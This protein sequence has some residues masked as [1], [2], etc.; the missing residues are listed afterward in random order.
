M[1][2]FGKYYLNDELSDVI[3]NI[4]NEI[5]PAHKL[6]LSSRSKVFE[7]MFSTEFKESKERE[8]TI[9]ET[10]VDAFKIF[11]KTIYFDEFDSKEIKDYL[12]AIEVFKLAHRYEIHMLSNIVEELIIEM[13]SLEN[14]VILIDFALVYDLNNLIKFLELFM[15]DNEK[16][17]VEKEVIEKQLHIF[18]TSDKMER[19][20]GF[21]NLS[22]SLLIWALAHISKNNMEIDMKQFRDLI[23]FEKCTV[24]D[25]NHLRNFRLFEEKELNEI[26]E[27]KFNNLNAKY[28][29]LLANYIKAQKVF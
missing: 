11:L 24:C 5:I 23:K 25:V 20:I 1:S 29:K 15:K 3:I 4:N 17:L 18:Y 2:Q 10:N 21:A 8:I 22:Q 12:V 9:N 26:I 19:F 7:K 16:Q 14:V 28:E 27:N 6:I 13:V